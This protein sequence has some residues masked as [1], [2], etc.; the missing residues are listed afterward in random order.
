M[1][2][3]NDKEQFKTLEQDGSNEVV[4]RVK[5]EAGINDERNAQQ[6]SPEGVKKLQEKTGKRVDG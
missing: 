1:F 3:D 6:V 2:S 4:Q 5:Q